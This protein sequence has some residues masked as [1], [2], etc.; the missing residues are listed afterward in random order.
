MGVSMI[1]FKIGTEKFFK[2]KSGFTLAEVLITLVVLGIISA[3]TI[4]ALITKTNGLKYRAQFKK[5]L[6]TLDQT[7]T[8]SLA[9]Y[10]FDYGDTKSTCHSGSDDPK[11]IFTFCSLLNGTLK[12]TTYYS[13]LN[14]IVSSKKGT[15]QTYT[16]TL[17]MVDVTMGSISALDYH[18]YQLADGSIIAFNKDAKNCTLKKMNELN[19]QWILSNYNCVGFIDVNGPSLPNKEVACGSGATRGSTFNVSSPCVVPNDANHM[20]DIYPVVFHDATIEPATSAAKYVLSTA[21]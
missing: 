19:V 7:G 4:P 12:G 5:T 21:K 2:E 15:Q 6:A 1:N 8:M 20:T 11:E 10:G 3:I 18:A 14:K 17:S 9:Y 13:N 16:K